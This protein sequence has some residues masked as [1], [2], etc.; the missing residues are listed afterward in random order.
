MTDRLES[1]T[2]ALRKSGA[3]LG[4]DLAAAFILAAALTTLGPRGRGTDDACLSVSG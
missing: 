2:T 3:E 4:R 1:P